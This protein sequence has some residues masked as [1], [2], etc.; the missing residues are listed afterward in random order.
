MREGARGHD[1][2]VD[3][4]KVLARHIRCVEGAVAIDVE[5]APR[6][7]YGLTIPLI[8]HRADVLFATGGPMTLVVSTSA[9]LSYAE[10]YR[11][12]ADVHLS[13]GEE[14]A[15]AIQ[16]SSTWGEPPESWPDDEIIRRIDDTLKA[17]QD[18]ESDHQSYE[19]PYREMVDLSGKVL[20][21]LTYRP[22]GAMVA[23]PT[24]SLPE[25]VGGERNWDYRYCWV[26]D[27]AFTLRALWVAACPDEANLYLDYMTA[28][29]SSVY[30]RNALQIMFG[31]EGERDL[32]ERALPWLQGWRDSRPVRVGNAAWT[33]TQH[34]VYGE[35]LL[36]VQILREQFGELTETERRLLVF[37]AD[38]ACEVW[39][40]PDHSIWEIRKDPQHYLHSKLMCWV[41]LDRAIRIV[42]DLGAEDRLES[43]KHERDEI[44][45][46]ILERGWSEDLG[47]FTQS[48]GS[49]ALDATSLV[50]PMVGLLPYEDPRIRST[51]E[52]VT[53]GLLDENGLVHRYRADDGLP[54]EEGAF[55]LCTFWL[56]EAL[57]GLGETT[58]ARELFES[59]VG[60][61][62][63]LGLL[64]E[65]VDP[66]S[67]ALIGNFP[68]A[69]SHVGLINAAWAISEAEGDTRSV[70]GIAV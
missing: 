13:E 37:L 4:P 7:E 47:A 54:G 11:A 9:D 18:W 30:D 44:R 42:S 19:G 65:E 5:F 1:L 51:V 31:I 24:T 27:A 40:E 23:A 28:A 39:R 29:A 21:G 46:A 25:S 15:F 34:D 26:R 60:F 68:Q 59:T 6:F 62:N 67:G 70:P 48:F 56:V 57:A 55:L 61:A 45:T 50:I 12:T 17:W 69:F 43:W 53:E 3:S 63:D 33:Q 32:S 20:E 14:V 38:T 58:E 41:A 52:A 49:T 16:A 2:G 35:L 8:Q 36:S 22:T 66:E 10:G 64:S